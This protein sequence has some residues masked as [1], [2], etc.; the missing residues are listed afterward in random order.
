MGPTRQRG[1]GAGRADGSNLAGAAV[2]RAERIQQL[3]QQH[4]QQHRARQGVY[5]ME[6]TEEI[7]E[8]RLQEDERRVGGF[9]LPTLI[10]LCGIWWVGGDTG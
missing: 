7:Y 4:Q 8:K 6:Q 5:P 10:R 3:R 9:R 1:N 2:S